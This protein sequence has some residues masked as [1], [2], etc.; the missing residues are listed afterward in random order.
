MENSIYVAKPKVVNDPIL[1]LIEIKSPI[2]LSLIEHRWLQRLR[3]INQ[4][5]LGEL[6]YPGA[7]HNR[8]GH[9]LG[10]TYLME[11]AIDTLRSKGEIISD[12]EKEAAMIAILLHD[13]GHCPFSHALEYQIANVC[14][15]DLS[16][17]FMEKL[18]EEYNGRL[19]LALQIFKGEYHKKYLTKL[20][21]G[22]LDVDRLDYLSRDSFFTGVTEGNV[23]TDRLIK[24]MAIDNDRLVV[25]KKGMYSIEKFL[26][27][28]RLMYWQVYLHKTVHSAEQLLISIL[29][30]A[31]DL[32]HK[33]EDFFA[34]PALKFF[35]THEVTVDD[36]RNDSITE[37][38]KTVLENFAMLDDSDLLV[39]VKTWSMHHDRVLSLLCQNLINRRLPKTMVQDKPVGKF[40][41]KYLR[42]RVMQEFNL[43]KAE[44]EY[45][46][47]SGTISNKA[48]S[49]NHDQILVK[50]KEGNVIE[51][52]KVADMMNIRALSTT[53]SKFFISWPKNIELE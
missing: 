17:V 25:E 41:E 2:I 29:R 47:S 10:A 50:E 15:E 28:R 7:R 53:I 12:E 6:V 43:T 45:F 36:F 18:N 39:S 14:H 3:R 8:F 13:I 42:E 52:E 20:I 31:K 49:Q 34:S 37:T 21:S 5:G 22:Q 9:T 33:G 19:S 26:V 48:Y 11:L 23:N 1:G 30:R 32:C 44:S 46:V 38:G 4:L 24:L 16:I 27:A 35:L 51:I 40:M